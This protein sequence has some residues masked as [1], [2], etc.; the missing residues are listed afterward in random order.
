MSVCFTGAE[1]EPTGAWNPAEKG[2]QGGSDIDTT[3]TRLRP[4]CSS[5][6]CPGG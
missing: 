3:A 4:E 6:R 5:I 1:E 2:E